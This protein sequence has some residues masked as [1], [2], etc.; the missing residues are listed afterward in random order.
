M[1]EIES[2]LKVV[3]KKF[4]DL[5]Y[6]TVSYVRNV[7]RLWQNFIDVYTIQKWCKEGF[8]VLD[9][10]CGDGRIALPLSQKFHIIGV[11]FSRSGIKISVKRAGKSSKTLAF[12]V[13][14]IE[15]LPFRERIFDLVYSLGTFE[16]FDKPNKALQEIRRCLKSSGIIIFNVWSEEA[17]RLGPLY[18]TLSRIFLSRSKKNRKTPFKIAV[19]S[20]SKI[21]RVIRE[22]GFKIIECRRH[23]LRSNHIILARTR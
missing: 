5:K 2:D 22:C 23:Y 1:T 12:L 19:Y 18:S 8:L 20:S 7:G 13:A 3:A 15:H 6:N 11:D 9:V 16:Y 21:R 10:G 17:I 4:Y 14:D